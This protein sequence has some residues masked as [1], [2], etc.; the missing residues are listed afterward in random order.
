MKRIFFFLIVIVLNVQ[1]EAQDSLNMSLLSRWDPSGLEFSDVWGWEDGS[2]GEYAIIGSLDSIH[3]IDVTDPANIYQADAVLGGPNSSIWRDFKTYQNYCYAVADQSGTSEGLIILD[4]SNLPNSVQV[5]DRFTDDF[6]R[7]HNIYIEEAT[8]RLY[9]VGA[10]LAGVGSI[11]VIIYDIA[12]D[13]E[14]PALLY[15]GSMGGYIHDIHVKDNI[16]YSS[17]GNPGLKV[18]DVSNT[19]SITQ[20]AS[21]SGYVQS[22]YNH[23]SW[24]TDDNSH[25]VF[26]DETR[27]RG[28]KIID[29]SDVQNGNISA[30][31]LFRS[32]LLAPADTTS[33]AHNPFIKGDYVYISYYHDGIQVFDISDPT[34][35][36]KVAYYDTDPNNTSYSG[37]RGSWGAYPYLSSGIILGSDIFNG[38]FVMGIDLPDDCNKLVNTIQAEGPGS[39]LNALS[40]ASSGDTITFSPTLNNDTI[41]ISEKS[42]VIDKDIAIIADPAQ[43]LY[44]EGTVV[45]TVF[46]VRETRKVTFEG[47]NIIAGG[48]AGGVIMNHGILT[49]RDVNLIDQSMGFLM[50]HLTNNGDIIVEGD[51]NLEN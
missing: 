30:S 48:A 6:T 19:S 28:V 23:S 37:S 10:R 29:V 31:D 32:A 12:T 46:D 11:N 43:N 15:S 47:L 20:I 21:Y 18:F 34:N 4:M 24:I 5:V 42:V 38:L 33:I 22:G 14:A 9:V 49:L 8:G 26:C 25:L 1:L 41:V 3:I 16:A 51:C 45:E 2:G 13:P 7:A 44:I 39:L 35:V 17:H 27:N 36:Q 40:C 50:N